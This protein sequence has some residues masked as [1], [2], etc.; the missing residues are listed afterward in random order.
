MKR[1]A[2]SKPNV[3]CAW[4]AESLV[5]PLVIMG[6]QIKGGIDFLGMSKFAE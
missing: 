3:F 5:I 2:K 4:I 6:T 1:R